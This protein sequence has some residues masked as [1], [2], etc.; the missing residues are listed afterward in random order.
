MEGGPEMVRENHTP[1]GPDTLYA[2]SPFLVS[3]LLFD[4]PLHYVLYSKYYTKRGGLLWQ[5]DYKCTSGPRQ[6]HT[7]FGPN[8]KT[9]TFGLILAV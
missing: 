6:L 7:E 3:S 1:N 5:V 9:T 4:T 8:I 2:F